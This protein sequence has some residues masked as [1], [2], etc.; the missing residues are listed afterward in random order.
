MIDS[1]TKVANSLQIL[2]LPSVIAGL[3]SAVAMLT[4][5]ITSESHEGDFYLIP[6]SIG[7]LWSIA[8]YSFLVNFRSVPEKAALSWKLFSRI[9]RNLIRAWYWLIAILFV[10]ATLAVVAVSYRMIAVWLRDYGV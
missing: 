8:T 1:F 3:L 7:L 6:S 9:K 5:I 2:R 4:V 10:G